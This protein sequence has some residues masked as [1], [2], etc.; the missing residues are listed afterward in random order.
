MLHWSIH[1]LQLN[2][3]Y[4]WKISRNATDFK[5][6]SIITCTDNIH[7]GRGE[8]APNI[9]YNE[10]PELLLASFEQFVNAGANAIKNA[11][12]LSLLLNQVNVPNALRF[13][14]EQ[15]YIH[16]LCAQRN[17]SIYEFLKIEQP[18]KT[19]TCYTL[20]IMEPSKVVTF[21]NENNLDRFAY[22]KI[23]ISVEGAL[24]EI[25]TL[26]SMYDKPILVDA[27]EAWKDPDALIN[28]MDSLK[29]LNIAMIEQPMHSSMVDEYKYVKPHVKLPLMADESFCAH[30][31]FNELKQQFDAVNMKL[32]KAGG[33]LN[34][35]RLIYEAKKYGL[36]TMV[37]C[38]VETTL[39][40][41][42]AYAFT[43][44]CNYADLDGYMI[45]ENEPY[46]LLQEVDGEV[47][48]MVDSR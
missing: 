15:A 25:K 2:L 22:L 40:M 20:P 14:I 41:S 30:V 9:R 6:N 5:V 12:D 32:M 21:F 10:T 23:K 47:Y 24:D 19:H 44:L 36:T 26:A 34:G 3:K 27:N 11:N 37:G 35:L 28:F 31:D 7:E 46:G 8:A 13:G 4:T 1:Q 38:M 39:G 33:Y 43:G 18:A 17:E 45:V 16:Y 48:L 42:G 29:G